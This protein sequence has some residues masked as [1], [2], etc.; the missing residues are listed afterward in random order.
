VSRKSLWHRLIE[1]EMDDACIRHESRMKSRNASYPIPTSRRSRGSVL[2]G[3]IAIERHRDRQWRLLHDIM[4]LS[5]LSLSLFFSLS[6]SSRRAR[7]SKSTANEIARAYRQLAN[8]YRYQI[9]RNAL[10]YMANVA[11]SPRRTRNGLLNSPCARDY[12]LFARLA[13]CIRRAQKHF[14]II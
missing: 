13:L 12:C 4:A 1:I 8:D 10:S 9:P 11:L 5:L 14:I 6:L 2:Q 3:A 7:E